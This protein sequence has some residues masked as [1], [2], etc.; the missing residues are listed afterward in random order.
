MKGE[1][2]RVSEG[3]RLEERKVRIRKQMKSR[4]IGEYKI[5]KMSECKNI[6]H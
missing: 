6:S 5:N 4:Y 3:K 2:E 1:R